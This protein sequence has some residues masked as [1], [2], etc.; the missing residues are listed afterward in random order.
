MRKH[1]WQLFFLFA[2]G[3]RDSCG[4]PAPAALAAERHFFNR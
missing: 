2:R 4:S 1:L 3:A